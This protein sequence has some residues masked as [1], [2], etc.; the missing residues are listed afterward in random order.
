MYMP[1]SLAGCHV[2]MSFY[3]YMICVCFTATM[4]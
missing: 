1:F 2:H 4:W 3:K